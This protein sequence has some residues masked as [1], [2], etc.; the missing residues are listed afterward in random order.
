MAN[1]V[2][3]L[4]QSMTEEPGSVSP[5]LVPTGND[6]SRVRFTHNYAT[7]DPSCF[8]VLLLPFHRPAHSE[9]RYWLN[10]E[11][12]FLLRGLSCCLA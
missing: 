10:S 6:D 8:L 5:A 7:A 9:P 4:G 3:L 1:R 12:V 11:G 2:S